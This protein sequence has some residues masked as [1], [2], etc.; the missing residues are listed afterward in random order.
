MTFWT[1]EELLAEALDV[2]V[3]ELEEAVVVLDESRGPSVISAVTDASGGFRT[4]KEA[5]MPAVTSAGPVTLP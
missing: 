4:E 2:P 3:V 5:T 1:H